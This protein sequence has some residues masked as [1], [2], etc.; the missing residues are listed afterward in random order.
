[1]D[2][3]LGKPIRNITREELMSLSA[4]LKICSWARDENGVYTGKANGWVIIMGTEDN[5]P[6]GYAL[7]EEWSITLE[8]PPLIIARVIDRLRSMN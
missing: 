1:M 4:A 3:T 7:H 2:S 6:K 8:I 5:Q